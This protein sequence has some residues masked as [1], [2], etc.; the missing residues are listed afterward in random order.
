MPYKSGIRN[1]HPWTWNDVFHTKKWSKDEKLVSDM[2]IDEQQMALAWIKSEMKPRK[3]PNLNQNTYF[4]KH[5][6]EHDTGIYMTNNQFKDAMLQCGYYP[7][8]ETELNWWYG[9]SEKS[10]ALKK[11]YKYGYTDWAGLPYWQDVNKDK[12]AKND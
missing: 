9:L 1:G 5:V 10:P 3:T 6:L 11:Y 2:P 7:V 8:D 12:I 4:L